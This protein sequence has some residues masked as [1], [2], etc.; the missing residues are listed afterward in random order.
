MT[1][2]VTKVPPGAAKGSGPYRPRGAA[3]SAKNTYNRLFHSAATRR[4]SGRTVPG[5]I[6]E[7]VVF[8]R[9]EAAAG[10]GLA[11]DCHR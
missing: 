9:E 7:G 3:K 6:P 2:Q 8:A 11:E 1:V 4:G 5:G 10:S